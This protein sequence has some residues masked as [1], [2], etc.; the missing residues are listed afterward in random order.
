MNI[1]REHDFSFYTEIRMSKSKYDVSLKDKS[2]NALIFFT[3][4]LIIASTIYSL[5]ISQHAD[6]FAINIVGIAEFTNTSAG[7]KFYGFILLLSCFKLLLMWSLLTTKDIVNK[8]MSSGALIFAVC[9]SSVIAFGNTCSEMVNVDLYY[10][11]QQTALIDNKIFNLLLLCLAC[12]TV[13]SYKRVQ[14][15]ENDAI[16][17]EVI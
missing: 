6:F 1:K 8:L 13:I 3:S 14:K 9:I 15:M 10:Y 5:Y 7:K 16:K 12:I 4:L 2:E 17:M 11:C